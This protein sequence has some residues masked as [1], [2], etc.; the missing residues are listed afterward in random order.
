[1]TTT[2][3][4]GGTPPT[5]PTPPAGPPQVPEGFVPI[6][7]LNTVSTELQTARS[8][9]TELEASLQASARHQEQLTRVWHMPTHLRTEEHVTGFGSMYDAYRQTAGQQALSYADWLNG[10]ARANPFLAPHFQG[11]S[12][13]PAPAP[14]PGAP[15]SAPPPGAPPAP[16]TPPPAPALGT[17]L[18]NPDNGAHPPG[19][20]QSLL[21]PD[22]VLEQLSNMTTEQQD[23]WI[24]ANAERYGVGWARKYF[25]TKKG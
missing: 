14:P 13:A 3:P 19:G 20:P 16:G 24:N 18:V 2:P 9:V 10:P 17:P 22:Q 8:R 21:N 6:G 11:Q 23:A 5:P 25:G 4:D 15:P 1:M 7:R 12:P